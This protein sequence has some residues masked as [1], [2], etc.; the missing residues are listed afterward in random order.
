MW[1]VNMN[2][3]RCEFRPADRGHDSGARRP[4]RWASN[5]GSILPVLRGG[6]VD[7]REPLARVFGWRL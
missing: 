7:A 1:F 6:D 3:R 4:K 5:S 2:P